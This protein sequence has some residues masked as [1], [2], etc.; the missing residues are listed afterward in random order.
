MPLLTLAQHPST[1]FLGN[2]WPDAKIILKD[3]LNI[4]F[5][6]SAKADTVFKMPV[7]QVNAKLKGVPDADYADLNDA[8][9]RF[10]KDNAKGIKI[11]LA[12]VGI[13]LVGYGILLAAV[14]NDN[15]DQ[16]LY[17]IGGAIAVAG[18]AI[19][20]LGVG[21]ELSSHRHLKRFAIVTGAVPY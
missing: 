16:S 15:A 9:L 19:S 7:S 11:Q 6:K 13:S 5:K 4:Y 18:G 14:T 12:G 20:L 2:T 1:D 21:I 8:L 3:S 10:S 17:D